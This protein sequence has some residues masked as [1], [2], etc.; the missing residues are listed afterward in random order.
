MCCQG[1]DDDNN[2]GPHDN[3]IL[4]RQ[5]QGLRELQPQLSGRGNR[6]QV[7]QGRVR[8]GRGHYYPRCRYHYYHQARGVRD[9]TRLPADAS[10]RLR[11]AQRLHL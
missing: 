4:L 11:R 2:F 7:H 1:E 10:G 6:V 8:R 9:C 3:T 5:P